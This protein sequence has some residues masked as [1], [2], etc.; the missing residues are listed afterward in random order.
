MKYKLIL[1]SNSP[2]RRELMDG[3]SIPYEVR[4]VKGIDEAYPDHLP[5]EEIPVFISREKAAAYR[6]ADDEMLITA[7]TI[8]WLKGRVLEKPKD[9]AEA[10]E[11]LR[12]LLNETHQVITGV[13][14]TT[15]KMQHSF[16][17]VSDVTFGPLT[18]QEIEQY[19]SRC[20]PF[21][22]AGAYGIQEWIGYIGVTGLRGSYFNVMGLPV[23]RLYA[24]L[25]RLNAI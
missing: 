12:A 19:V 8:V 3:L 10:I 2:R 11:M 21:D 25:K 17:A 13:S 9:E 15:N 16:S 5:P 14:L 20:K 6:L 22:K 4:L 1:A 18:D 23:Q 24:E 7:D